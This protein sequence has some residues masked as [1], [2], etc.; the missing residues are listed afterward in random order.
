MDQAATLA[1]FD[2]DQRKNINYPGMRREVTPRVVR[3]IS[4]SGLAEGAVVY[5]QLDETNAERVIREEIA[6]FDRIGQDFEWKLFDYDQPADLK[7]R[8][9]ALGFTIEE[10]EALVLLALDEAPPVL[11][12]PVAHDLRRISDPAQLSDVQYIEETVWNEDQ[13]W[14]QNYLGEALRDYPHQMSV[15][16]AYVEDQPASAAWIYYPEHSQFA[17]L[18]GGSTISQYRQQGLYTALLSVRA[19]EARS[20]GRRFLT[21]EASPMSRPILEK[22]GFEMLAYTYPCKWTRSSQE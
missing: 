13:S 2:Q 5:S 22:H 16:A 15:F 11:W 12:E 21:V 20:R 19:Q 14:I 17:S 18:W 8:L 3:L 4:L 9:S 10:A 7:D 6:Y 1:L